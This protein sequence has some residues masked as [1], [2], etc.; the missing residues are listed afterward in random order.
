[1]ADAAIWTSSRKKD[2]E[3]ASIIVEA[4]GMRA[5]NVVLEAEN[6]RLMKELEAAKKSRSK[7]KSKTKKKVADETV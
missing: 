6:A 1:M 3:T 5:R 2:S 4:Q 7:S